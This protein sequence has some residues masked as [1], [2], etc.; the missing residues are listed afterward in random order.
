M[1]HRLPELGDDVLAW[2]SR[3]L[4]SEQEAVNDRMADWR[5]D[6]VCRFEA[7]FRQE[8]EAKLSLADVS[9]SLPP[10]AVEDEAE[11]SEPRPAA[12]FTGTL[13]AASLWENG[14]PNGEVNSE[15]A[16][17]VEE[18]QASPIALPKPWNGASQK[19]KAQIASENPSVDATCTS[20]LSLWS[21]TSKKTNNLVKNLVLVVAPPV[22][23]I[24]ESPSE[25]QK[26]KPK[27]LVAVVTSPAF[28]LFFLL[29]IILNT[30]V[31]IVEAQHSGFETGFS[32][33]HA[34]VSQ[35]VEEIWPGVGKSLP[36]LGMV[37]GVLFTFE[38]VIKLLALRK[39][40][41]ASAWNLF[42]T[43]VVVA[44]LLDFAGSSELPIDPMA[45]RLCR[46]ARIFRM[47]RVVRNVGSLHSLQL[48]VRAI[49]AS[50]GIL[51]WSVSLLLGI[52][53]VCSLCLN[54]VLTDYLLDKDTP[55]EERQLVY[56][57]FGTFTRTLVTM[58]ELTLANWVP[59]CELL[60][61][62]VNEWYALPLLLYKCTAGYAV[63]A[64]ITGV[65]LHETFD[66][67]G[68]DDTVMIAQRERAMLKHREK[69]GH[70]FSEC[71]TSGDGKLLFDEFCAIVDDPRA[72]A[73]FSAMGLD[74]HDA[75]TLFS[76]LDDG[77]RTLT[78]DELTRGVAWLKGPARA[79]DIAVLHRD[80]AHLTDS[81]EALQNS[82]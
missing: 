48:L 62:H 23:L 42:D 1:A 49:V 35:P 60:T 56:N 26:S 65:F 46:L 79:L 32:I 28:E 22:Q 17:P 14:E 69:M 72:R 70:I 64:V 21:K 73:W 55:I 43:F 68:T 20:Q 10:R 36:A 13:H 18:R 15:F 6:L 2:L 16:P 25:K 74:V 41:F 44:W 57:K 59:A 52:M 63:L 54:H 24:S 76:L 51:I 37:F 12:V 39:D 78:V 38:V 45:L 27:G 77:D 29:V 11:V 7:H 50:G 31:M 3:E 58:F 4:L 67:A 9:C 40:F 30:V 34:S 75:R 47:L 53:V 33:G 61:E 19:I 80:I 71:D 81:V 8:V 66:V 82:V 5:R